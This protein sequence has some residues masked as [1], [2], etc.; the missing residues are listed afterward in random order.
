MASAM[1]AHG[2]TTVEKDELT[3]RARMWLHSWIAG[4]DVRNLGNEITA[5]KYRD[6]ILKAKG[7]DI[8]KN[9]IPIRTDRKKA[10]AAARELME[11]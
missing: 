6:V 7:V 8:L 11:A 10:L 2:E 9:S 4:E 5:R 3:P 1:E